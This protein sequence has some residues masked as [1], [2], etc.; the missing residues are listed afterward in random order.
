MARKKCVVG[1]KSART[2]E[3]IHIYGHIFDKLEPCCNE[4]KYWFT[5]TGQNKI[6]SFDHRVEEKDGL[7]L[8][9]RGDR[10]TLVLKIMVPPRESS[11]YFCPFCGAK[12]EV[13]CTKSVILK[14][15]FKQIPDGHDE[16]IA[17][18]EKRRTK[19]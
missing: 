1:Y 2:E 4:F 7:N 17:W 11:V 8:V 14:K 19:K 3:S 10:Q 15:R 13:R 12:V 6:S 16:E 9:S 18:E 5:N